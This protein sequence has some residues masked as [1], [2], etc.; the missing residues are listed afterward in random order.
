MWQWFKKRIVDRT[1]IPRQV[2]L[3]RREDFGDS[4]PC[5]RC[6][7]AL[8]PITGQVN[9]GEYV[10]V[11]FCP[12]CPGYLE[13]PY[14]QAALSIGRLFEQ[15]MFKENESPILS[16]PIDDIGKCPKCGKTLTAQPENQVCGGDYATFISCECGGY[17]RL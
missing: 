17:R 14:E 10:C 15:R 3:D 13:V 5:P 7:K 4:E 16:L 2:E 1:E 12:Y 6:G 8:G 11:R 9:G